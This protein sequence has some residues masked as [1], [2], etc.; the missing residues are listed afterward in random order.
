MLAMFYSGWIVKYQSGGGGGGTILESPLELEP[1][2]LLDE[3]LELSESS[4]HSSPFQ[5][6]TTSG[7]GVYPVGNAH[8][9]GRLKG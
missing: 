2:E 4:N 9:A 6:A 1:D 7:N 8:P 3:L 5:T